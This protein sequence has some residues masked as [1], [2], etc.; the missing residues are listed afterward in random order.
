MTDFTSF[1]I[2][3]LNLKF[4]ENENYNIL[5]KYIKFIIMHA[6]QNISKRKSYLRIFYI[7]LVIIYYY[8]QFTNHELT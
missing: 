8:N 6:I 5:H 1:F 2:L 7:K 4:V 3:F